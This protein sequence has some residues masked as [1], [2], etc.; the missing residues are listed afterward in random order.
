MGWIARL[1]NRMRIN[2]AAATVELLLRPQ[3]RTEFPGA[4]RLLAQQI[5]GAQCAADPHLMSG[6]VPYPSRHALAAHS[7]AG[8][9][10]VSRGTPS[11]EWQIPILRSALRDILGSPSALSTASAVDSHLY[12]LASGVLSGNSPG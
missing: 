12:M 3:W 4:A 6:D 2:D 11:M 10:L 8:A 7:L 5:V 9:L 1:F